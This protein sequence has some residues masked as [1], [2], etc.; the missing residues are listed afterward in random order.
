MRAGPERVSG[1]NDMSG[2]GV[3]LI[4]RARSLVP[5]LAQRAA[6]TERDRMVPKETIADMQAAGLF[7]V[8]QPK[9]WGGHE[10]GLEI[11]TDIQLILAEGCLSSAWVFGVIAAEPFLIALCDDRMAQDVWGRDRSTLVCGTSAAD[12]KNTL[13]A[14]EGGFRLSGTWRFASGCD[15]CDWAFLGGAVVAADG[16]STDWRLLLPKADYQIVGPWNV[17]GLRGTGSRDIVVADKFIPAHRAIKRADVFDSKGPGLALNT[18][19][20]Y[21]IPF[22]QVFS[23]GVSTLVIGGL[24]G[25]LDAFTAYGAKRTARGIGPTARDPVAQLLC[26]ETAAQI[27]ESKTIFRRNAANLQAYAER[28]E[29]PPM[30]ERMQYK[31]QL[32]FAVERASLLAARLFKAAGASGIYVEN[33]P[34]ARMLADINAGRSHVNNQFELYGRSWGAVLLGGSES[35]GRDRL[36]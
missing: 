20:V 35:E 18:A 23:F 6:Q 36:L 25:M 15:H 31:F 33:T 12:A 17:S 26:A 28:G 16:T 11:I 30:R 14:V 19:P 5:V 10:L 4:Q 13:V 7:Q 24:Q 27:D 29:I 3:E 34:F 32:A 8:M 2:A 9:R 1:V 22:G 21:R